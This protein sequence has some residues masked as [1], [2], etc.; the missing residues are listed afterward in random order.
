MLLIDCFNTIKCSRLEQN[1]MHLIAC[2]FKLVWTWTPKIFQSLGTC[3]KKSIWDPHVAI[4]CFL[5]IF[6]PQLRIPTYNIVLIV[7]SDFRELVFF[8]SIKELISVQIK[9]D[10]LLLLI[11]NLFLLIGSLSKCSNYLPWFLELNNNQKIMN[12]VN[13]SMQIKV[14]LFEFREFV[15]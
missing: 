4:Y 11:W 7:D 9:Q 2:N 10:T 3:L 15:D 6:Y 5:S 12:L 1:S 14:C 8:P 13:K